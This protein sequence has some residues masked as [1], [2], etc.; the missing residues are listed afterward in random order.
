MPP[1]V[2]AAA[3]VG[4]AWGGFV[5]VG[6]IVA[7]TL[8]AVVVGGLVGGAVG[9]GMEYL[10]DASIP[11]IANSSTYKGRTPVYTVEE[12][13]EIAKCY[14]RCRIAGN[15]IRSNDPSEENIKVI[16][17][18]GQGP[19]DS[20]LAWRINN[21]EWDYLE[22]VKWGGDAA[23]A[24]QGTIR[25]GWVGFIDETFTIDTQ[26]FTWKTTRS[27][28]GEVTLGTTCQEA[29]AN[30]VI[31]VTADLATVTAVT[32]GDWYVLITAVTP[33]INGNNILFTSA[34]Q[35]MFMNG[36]GTLGGTTIG[37]ASITY[38]GSSHFKNTALGTDSQNPIQ[39]NDTDLFTLN[40]CSY[41]GVAHTGL[42]LKKTSQISNLSSVLVEGLFTECEPIG[43]GT[44]VFSRNPAVI[45]WDFYRDVEN[46][47]IADLDIN[48]FKSLEALCDVY[49]TSGDGGPIRPPGPN[50]TTV[51]ATSHYESRYAPFFSFDFNLAL[52]GSHLNNQWLS[53]DG[54]KTNQRLNIDLGISVMLTKMVMINGHSSGSKLN[55]GIQNFVIQ[56]SNNASDLNHTNYYDGASGWTDIQTGLTATQ[57]DCDDPY[58]NYTVSNPA[59]PYRYY[60]IKIATNYGRSYMGIRDVCFW[61]RSPRYTFDF[62]F[63][64]EININDAK[65]LIW[66]SFNG[67]V[68]RSQGKLKPVWD[69][70]ET[71]NG[72]GGLTTKSSQYSFTM[73]NIVKD[74]FTWSPVER[75]NKIVIEYLDSSEGFKKTSVTDKDDSDIDDRGEII[76][77]T[78]TYYITQR[79][80][81]A[82]RCRR[83]L[84]HEMY[85]DY[86]CRLIGFPSS[87]KLEVYDLVTVTHTLP[88]WS[89][90]KFIILDKTEDEQGRPA[91]LLE[92][93]YA[94]VFD[95]V[96]TPFP[97]SYF[98]GL[99]NPLTAPSPSTD[100][101]AVLAIPGDGFDYL[102]VI[103]SFTPPME[104]AFYSHSEIYA[105]RND[106]GYY[107]VGTSSG[108]NFIINGNGTIYEPDDTCYIKLV[109]VSEAGVKQV[110]PISADASVVISGQIKSSSF[111][112]GLYDIWG[113]NEDISHADTKI[114]MG[115]LD[116]I[117]K[118]AL[119]ESADAITYAGIQSGFFVDGNGYMRVGSST[120]GLRFDPTSGVLDVPTKIKVGTGTYID[121]DGENARIRSSDYVSGYMGA[122]FT[123]EPDLL[124]VGNIACRGIFRTSVFQKDTISVIGGN[125]LVTRGDV[126]ATDMTASGTSTLTIEGNEDFSVGDIL[127]MKDGF[128]DE[129]LEVTDIGSAPTYT[130]TRDKSGNYGVDD[131]PA[132]TK[133]VCVTDYQQSGD[134]AVYMTASET[135]APYMSVFTH[136]GSPWSA[137]T[138]RLR[139]GNLNGFLGYVSDLYGIAIGETNKYLKYDPTNGLRI[140]GEITVTGGDAFS[141]TT[142]DLD[143]IS[144]GTFYSKV[145]TT[146]ISAGKIVLTSAGVTGSLAT[147]FTDAKCTDA[148]ADQTGAH[149]SNNTSYVGSCPAST[150]AGWRY[151]NTTYINGGDI[152]T[153][154]VTANKISVTDLAAINADLGTI[155]AGNMTLNSSGFV[156]TSGKDNYADT[157]PGFFL[158]YDGG[159]YK[160]NI[161]SSTKYLKW[162]GSDLSIGGDVIVTGNIQNNAITVP[163][164]AYV[165]GT[166]N[167]PLYAS[168]TV[169]SVQITTH[170]SP[171]YINWSC[172][173]VTTDG[174]SGKTAAKLFRGT[175]L[176]Q[177]TTGLVVWAAGQWSLY[178]GGGVDTPGAGTYTYTL[179]FDQATSPSHQHD[180]KNRS[181]FVMEIRR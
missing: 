137:L 98:S 162:D 174:S 35:L 173:G 130:V 103:V 179:R 2:I 158:G 120:H 89:A 30:I 152:Y 3:A 142:D 145:A 90:K 148:N 143:N 8:G 96:A 13:K 26:T 132:W 40:T 91:F 47:E 160:L 161:G 44:K 52:D 181:L 119:G 12:G 54:Q 141:K 123:L 153:N 156:R 127:R 92:A 175:T 101:V 126:L 176:L 165:A 19:I 17:G 112:A 42:S 163:V 159:A 66:S 110:M 150:V 14:G 166:I 104:D 147:G 95:D 37:T 80:V 171:V 111:Y 125:V 168:T 1:V 83:K 7:T 34:T 79:D 75:A 170:G 23:V 144:N 60:S 133:G 99:D 88:V 33:G 29:I 139:I 65:K 108:G 61:G 57:Y 73:D 68:I 155:T 135:N 25:M 22:K 81:A 10:T 154:T 84:Y 140:K 115:N 131:N 167:C 116:G 63:D 4:A 93:Y 78:T 15:V 21:I 107:M 106:S 177:T 149:T 77:D 70:S 157:T 9:Y 136:A 46:Y 109:S 87:Q 32:L 105:S 94:G 27:Q 122:G 72:S 5:G 74:S 113:G 69:W 18:H 86:Q 11:E 53:E 97:P 169:V 38:G 164:S 55:Q 58:K 48:A 16:I 24:A 76:L 39:V 31:A 118:I 138:T 124:E 6:A 100:I 67:R 59:T 64:T 178:N 36:G 28:T 129:W 121:I 51:K 43:G 128:D 114:V 134:G 56:G 180:I 20:L 85:A 117:P 151:S 71:A 45:M 172:A 82:R 146:A 62:N 41:R 49:P 102:A 50:N